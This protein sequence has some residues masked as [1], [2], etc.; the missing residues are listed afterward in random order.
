MI[1]IK[2]SIFQINIF[3]VT[4]PSPILVAM[5]YNNKLYQ[6]LFNRH[7]ATFTN[8]VVNG[9]ENKTPAKIQAEVIK[10]WKENIKKE[11]KEPIDKAA[12]EKEMR[13]LKV[14]MDKKN[15]GG[16]D[17]F[18]G[19]KLKSKDTGDENKEEEAGTSRSNNNIPDSSETVVIESE[20]LTDVTAAPEDNEEAVNEPYR[21]PAQEK[22][23]L[24]IETKEKILSNLKA[25]RNL[26]IVDAESAA[27]ITKRIKVISEEKDKLEKT[28][29]RKK[30]CQKAQMKFRKVEQDKKAKLLKE[31]PEIA[32][33]LNLKLQEQP[34]RP[35]LDVDQ[36]GMMGD[37]LK[38]A[39][40]GAACSDK[41]REDLFRT[42]K[43]LDDLHR[44]LTKLGYKISRS[45]LYL[46][47]LPRDST[48]TEGRRHYNTVPVKLVRPQNNLRKKHPDRMFAREGFRIGD[49]IAAHVGPDAAL[50]L[51]QDDKSS[52]PLGVTAA[53]KQGSMLMALKVRVRLPDHDFKVGSRHLLTPSVIT[54]CSIDPKVG[55]TYS[56][57]TYV[58]IRSA[59]HNGSSA[60]SHHEDLVKFAAVE[61]RAFMLEDSDT[62]FKPVIIKGVD[63]GP[64]ENPRFENNINMACKTFQDFGLDLLMEVT[65]APGLSAYNRAERRMFPLSKALT[66]VVL[67][68]ETFGSHLDNQGN[69]VDTELEEKNFKAAG[70]VLAE[71]WNEMEVDKYKV[72]A[73]FIDEA[74]KD[75]TK[76]FKPAKDFKTKHVLETQYFTIVLKCDDRTCCKP[77]KT[78]VA[79]FF[80]NRRIPALIPFKFSKTGPVALQLNK[81]VFKEDIKFHDIFGRIVLENKIAPNDLLVKYKDN[82]PFDVFFPSLQDK[83][84]KRTCED[85]QKYHASIKSLTAHRR[86]AHPKRRG[87]GTKKT[88]ERQDFIED[89]FDDTEETP[90]S[91]EVVE[92][93]IEDEIFDESDDFVE[94]LGEEP[95]PTVSVAMTSTIVKILDLKEWLKSP[96]SLDE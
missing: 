62:E 15:K 67:P 71:I 21:C 25:S 59:K 87:R 30:V 14:I 54:V 20:S 78:N 47:L 76:K 91:D 84:E 96:W 95:G 51:S 94:E 11:H 19:K 36:P 10:L 40:Y 45:G 22:L 46:R 24:E 1:M 50:Y 44:E 16:I 33:N 79:S 83:V 18:F 39:T 65:N 49:D 43:T 92:R 70:Q 2:K 23:R 27:T 60:F 37:I 48:T 61:K 75:E 77:F 55:V 34:G 81:E 57:A 90:L 3:V 38:I 68:Y 69:T 8:N 32:T 5:D 93:M 12:Y 58:G 52:V 9:I 63:G 35:S 29:K 6:D 42:I 56:G 80:P 88:N 72:T 66:G 82:L 53:K 41:R 73:E 74:V 28:L 7:K 4:L 17:S 86:A 31:F 13:K 85:C 26:G 89:E 64:D